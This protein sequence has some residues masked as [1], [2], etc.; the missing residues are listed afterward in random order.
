[1]EQKEARVQRGEWGRELEGPDQVLRP[2]GP[3]EKGGFT[4]PVKATGNLKAEE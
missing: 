2:R 1:M 3:A 4:P